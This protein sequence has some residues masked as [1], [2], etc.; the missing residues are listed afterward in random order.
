MSKFL[1]VNVLCFFFSYVC[2]FFF[3]NRR[4][5]SKSYSILIATAR[6]TLVKV[7]LSI[8]ETM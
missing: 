1:D 7:L 2:L 8:D 5:L 4:K 6:N 3:S